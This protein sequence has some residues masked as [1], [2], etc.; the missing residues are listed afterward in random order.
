MKKQKKRILVVEDDQSIMGVLEEALTDEGYQVATAVNGRDALHEIAVFKPHLVLTDH[1]MP[2]VTGFE[3]LKELRQQKNYVTVIF[4]SARSDSSFVAQALREGAD[5]Y[6]KKPF[7]IEELFARIE[8]SLRNNNLHK[9]LRAANE[10]LQELIEK[11]YLTGLYNMRSMYDR[12]D[13]EL[14]R[15]RRYK[16]TVSCIMIDMDY[17]KTVN[18]D[19]DHLFGSFVLSEMG[20]IIKNTMRD[21]DFA[22]RYGGDEFLVVLTEA[23]KEGTR[24]FC[25]RLRKNV[26]QNIFKQNNDEIKLT[27]SLGF[28]VSIP[29]GT[30]D[31][32]QLVRQA[33]NA[34]YHSKNKGRN[35]TSC[36]EE[37]ES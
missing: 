2:D 30:V 32:R 8:A 31:A 14:R 17:F 36:F 35:R 1:N 24:I 26:E 10:K 37:I 5:D 34:L 15:G 4:L 11:D 33:D 23:D 29:D 21:I 16:R 28:S 19:H 13:Y 12:I 7:R 20:E 25:E 9:E 3:M 22:A 6:I 27:A 18:D